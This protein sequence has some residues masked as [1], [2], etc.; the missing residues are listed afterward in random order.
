MVG[1]TEFYIGGTLGMP[2]INKIQCWTYCV[3]I[4]R[5]LLENVQNRL[6]IG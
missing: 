1:H 2:D 4:N 3:S 5:K 6:E